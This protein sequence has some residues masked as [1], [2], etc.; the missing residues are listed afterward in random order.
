MGSAYRAVLRVDRPYAAAGTVVAVKVLHPAVLVSSPDVARRFQLEAVAGLRV[1]HG[2]V[3]A[4]YE[5]DSETVAGVTTPFLVLEYVAGRSLE[6]LLSTERPLSE[7]VVRRLGSQ[8]AE[9]LN[10]IHEAGFVHRD[11]KPSNVMVTDA[12]EVKLADLGLA[13]LLDGHQGI[14]SFGSFVGSPLYASPEQFEGMTLSA[15]SDL[16]MLGT[17]LY[18]AATGVQPFLAATFPA[19]MHRHLSLVP[20][21]ASSVHP[22]VSAF[23]DE[24]L[25]SLL[26]KTVSRRPAS[27]ALVAAILAEGEDHPWYAERRARR[28]VWWSGPR[29]PWRTPETSIA[30]RD[31]EMALASS[32]YRESRDGR[33]RLLVIEGEAGVGKTRLVE[34]L[35]RSLPELDHTPAIVLYGRQEPGVSG[36]RPEVLTRAVVDLLGPALEARLPHI[37][38]TAPRSVVAFA[39]YLRERPGDDFVTL[40]PSMIETLMSELLRG[41]AGEAPVIWVV[42]DLH[43]AP[44]ATWDLLRALVHSIE[45]HRVF[46]VATLRSGVPGRRFEEVPHV[47]HL[48]LPRLGEAATRRVLVELVSSE[49][50]AEEILPWALRWSD[51]NA[52]LLLEGIKHLREFATLVPDGGGRLHLSGSLAKVAVPASVRELMLARVDRLSD[53]KRSLLDI[54]SV[55]GL[56]LDPDLIARVGGESRLSVLQALASLERGTGLVRV[57]GDRFEFDHLQLQEVIRDAIPPALRAEYHLRIARSHETRRGLDGAPPERFSEDDCAFLARHYLRARDARGLELMLR[58]MDALSHRFR[59]D[60]VIELAE[61]AREQVVPPALSYEVAVREAEALRFAGRFAES[62]DAAARAAEHA[63]TGGDPAGVARAEHLRG[64]SFSDQ[65]RY[66]EAIEALAEAE[67]ASC[68]AGDVV[69]RA[70]ALC[71]A[72]L[73][74]TFLGQ[75]EDAFASARQSRELFQSVGDR[76]GEALAL[77]RLSHIA[78]EFGDVVASTRHLERMLEVA[79]PLGD[80]FSRIGVQNLGVKCG[81]LGDYHEAV[82]LLQESLRLCR[83]CGDR[84]AECVALGNLG[85]IRRHQGRFA[86][87]RAAYERSFERMTPFRGGIEEGMLSRAR[88]ELA[89]AEGELVEA[90]QHLQRAV[91]ISRS[92]GAA[93]IEA[94]AL[95]L[96]SHLSRARG[97]SNQECERPL[98]EAMGIFERIGSRRGIAD[99]LVALGRCQL[100]AGDRYGARAL[101]ERAEAMVIPGAVG[102]PG[103]LPAAYLALLGARDAATVVVTER[104]PHMVRAEAH[105]VLGDAGG[106]DTHRWK[107]TELIGEM[108]ERRTDGE[109]DA[110]WRYNPCARRLRPTGAKRV[111][112]GS[113]VGSVV[114]EA[115][116]DEK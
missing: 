86:E 101:F 26:D 69:S 7:P 102:Q 106:P 27:A 103:P 104:A 13:T 2:A 21:R 108:A 9:A 72:A 109:D 91:A 100:D 25:A 14:T 111:G 67:R 66:R 114:R 49:A 98:R 41:L 92:S 84:R 79:A 89:L 29:L 4:T 56:V 39:S 60:D 1:R 8:L 3:V 53:E 62:R 20:A 93:V 70:Q 34:E 37:L 107:A 32:L 12:Y 36:G 42:E 31:G 33:G 95:L 71:D 116:R 73:G 35:L 38:T 40:T 24:I 90:E 80:L 78:Y 45:G 43:L 28:Q 57:N 68:L 94:D 44:A 65:A 51:G 47:R 112:A 55:H 50:L 23:L 19:I 61:L 83:E 16:Y 17:V 22:R 11:V 15:S 63:R 99:L 18:E 30:G 74:L 75:F 76:R 115:Q 59:F 110:F 5:V 82:R 88:A 87:S 52:F 10:V 58:A 64:R 48:R 77:S 96:F 105:L 97:A 81:V 85:E 113:W 46:M 54:A 6:A